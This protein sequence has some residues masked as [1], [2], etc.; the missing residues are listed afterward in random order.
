MTK[1]KIEKRWGS[2]GDRVNC[3]GTAVLTDFQLKVEAAQGGGSDDSGVNDVRFRCSNGEELSVTNGGAEG[4]WGEWSDVCPL[5][6]CGIEVKTESDQ[7][8]IIDDTAVNDARFL[9]C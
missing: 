9:C 7:G 8:A 6:I 4:E 1:S 3:L 5:G 2:W